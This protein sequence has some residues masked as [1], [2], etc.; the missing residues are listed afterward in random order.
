MRKLLLFILTVTA[1]ISFTAVQG[2]TETKALKKVDVYYFHGN[3]RCPTCN[4]IE[5]ETKALLDSTFK[6]QM[7]A[8]VIKLSVLNHEDKKNE[9]LVKKYE[10]WGSSLLLVDAKGKTINLTEMA[11]ANARNDAP[12]FKRKLKAEINKLLK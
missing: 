12:E 9:T 7:T 3:H 5:K 4:A 10:I 1:A 6:A 11:F 8:G 2:Q